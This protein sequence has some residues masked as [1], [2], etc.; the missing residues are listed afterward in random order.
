MGLFDDTFESNKP[1]EMTKHEAFAGVLL[2]A[3]ASDGHIADEEVRGLFTVLFRMKMYDNWT[4]DKMNNTINRLLGI[5]KREGVDAL[6]NRCAKTLPEDLHQTA[7]ANACDIILADGVVED[8]EKEFINR[9]WKVLGISGD[10]AKTIAQVMVIKN[11][12]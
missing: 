1:R 8:E 4:D 11:R 12:G 6:L 2:G 9:L 5:I 7:F 10:D 3:S